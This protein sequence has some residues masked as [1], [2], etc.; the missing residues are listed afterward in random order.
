MVSNVFASMGFT[1]CALV[2]LLLIGFMYLSKKKFKDMANNI[3]A[4]MLLLTIILLI[5]EITCV[6]TMSIRDKIPV[7]NEMLCRGYILGVI[8][9]V[10]S[11]IIYV[12][13]LGNTN[14][15][16][17]NY[18]KNNIIIYTIAFVIVITLFIISCLSPIAYTG[19][20][21]ELYVIGGSATTVIYIASFIVSVILVFKLFANNINASISQ[22]APIYFV[23]TFFITITAWQMLNNYDFNDLTFILSFCV[24]GLY[25]TIESQDNKLLVELEKSKKEAEVADKAKTEFLINMSHEIRTPMNTILGFS[26]ALLNE[27]KLTE[28]IVKRDV[29]SIHTASINLLDL[30][31]NILDISRIESGK[32]KLEEREY[33]LENLV[34]EINSIFSSKVNKNILEFNINVNKN[35]PSKYYGDYSKIHKIIICVLMNALKYTK[36]GKIDLKIDGTKKENGEFIFNF[37]VIN[38]G[39]AMKIEDFQK[40]FNDFVKIGNKIQNTIDSVTLGLIIAKRL[41]TMLDG[42]ISFENEPDHGTQYHITFSQKIVDNSMVGDIFE[43]RGG[44]DSSSNLIDCSGKRILIVDDNKINIKLA[45][46]I[47]KSY[48]F[49]ID[50]VTNGKDCIEKVKNNRYDLIFLD[51]MMPEMDGVVTLKV[52]KSSEY[53]IPPVIALTANSYAGLKEKYKE[54]GFSDYLAKPINFK[55]LNKLINIYFGKR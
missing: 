54:D 25:F 15:E 23:V 6:Y 2:F 35:I 38:T 11:L 10:A 19:G 27:K 32:E 39:H 34:F 5:L 33:S 16:K 21:G 37:D 4:F 36:Y 7:I 42:K 47:L 17:K 14:K 51:H 12:W 49:E 53:Y 18:R 40:D 41:L 13:S 52:M 31:N 30:I 26:E 9:W 22:R 45:S 28:N 50:S 46:R 1:I 8:I 20:N 29:E 48:N 43:A 3:Y 44:D 55:E 24:T